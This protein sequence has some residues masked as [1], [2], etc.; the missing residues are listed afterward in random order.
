ML[1]CSSRSF[2][3]SVN[4]FQRGPQRHYAVRLDAAGVVYL[5][6]GTGS[7]QRFDP[8]PPGT[9]THIGADNNRVFVRTA[10]GGLHWTCMVTDVGAWVEFNFSALQGLVERSDTLRALLDLASVEYRDRLDLDAMLAELFQVGDLWPTGRAPTPPSAR[11]DL[12]STWL[13]AYR[14]WLEETHAVPPGALHGPWSTLARPAEARIATVDWSAVRDVAVA[15]WHHTVVTYLVL[16]EDGR[17]LYIDEE[18]MMPAWRVVPGTEDARIRYDAGI[19]DDPEVVLTASHSVI[20]LLQPNT[21]SVVWRRFDYH[22]PSDF[23]LWP[24]LNWT[25]ASWTRRQV[26]LPRPVALRLDASYHQSGGESRPWPTP[27]PHPA[28]RGVSRNNEAA[29]MAEI[30]LYQRLPIGLDLAPLLILI[31]HLAVLLATLPRYPDDEGGGGLPFGISDALMFPVLMLEHVKFSRTIA[32]LCRDFPKLVDELFAQFDR[33]PPFV[34]HTALRDQARALRQADHGLIPTLRA[35]IEQASAR[36]DAARG[37]SSGVGAFGDNPVRP[38]DAWPLDLWVRDTSGRLAHVGAPQARLAGDLRVRDDVR[39]P[40]EA[41]ETVPLRWSWTGPP[42]RDASGLWVR[43][44]R[45][46]VSDS[47]GATRSYA[48]T[49]DQDT[50]PNS[51]AVIPDPSYEVEVRLPAARAPVIRVEGRDA[52]GHRMQAGAAIPPPRPAVSLH[53]DL[54][55][56]TTLGPPKEQHFETANGGA[57]SRMKLTRQGYGL[58]RVRLFTDGFLDGPYVVA[59]RASHHHFANLSAQVPPDTIEVSTLPKSPPNLSLRGVGGLGAPP[60]RDAFTTLNAGPVTVAEPVAFRL[61]VVVRDAQGQEAEASLDLSPWVVVSGGTDAALPGLGAI[62]SAALIDHLSW[63][64]ADLRERLAGGLAEHPQL[65]GAL[66]A[67]DAMHIERDGGGIQVG[68][69]ASFAT[70]SV[71]AVRL[72]AGERRAPADLDA[73]SRLTRAGWIE[74]HLPR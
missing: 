50:G 46:Q 36:I 7:W 27:S 33:D 29:I 35:V 65:R 41:P 58:L 1:E 16:L 12:I 8:Q 44:L 28:L 18:P 24:L 38:V 59:W 53:L 37:R 30:M 64:R 68:G 6:Q 52:D 71:R 70:S 21:Q 55:G 34:P 32:A 45:A 72:D 14:R 25:E 9:V 13:G 42:R 43:P 11:T 17:L 63:L 56:S 19:T 57:V 15:N 31:G 62:E 51:K 39:A 61:T 26:P 3:A 49:F 48:W 23:K 69:L 54:A 20:A 74:V 47:L 40:E 67:L 5:R 22:N 10:D 73:V 60:V 66:E 2:A 4:H